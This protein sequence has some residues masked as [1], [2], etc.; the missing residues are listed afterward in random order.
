MERPIWIDATSQSVLADLQHRGEE[1]A[2]RY[3][4]EFLAVT[5]DDHHPEPDQVP[6][7]ES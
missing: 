4:V 2:R 5:S 3:L 1:T 7:Q 6:D